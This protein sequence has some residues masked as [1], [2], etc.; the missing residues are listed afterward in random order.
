VKLTPKI[1]KII[2]GL[3]AFAAVVILPLYAV[4]VHLKV[5]YTDFLV[6]HRGGQRALV[7]GAVYNLGD[8][9]SPFRY[10]PILIPLFSLL[11]RL[12]LSTAQLLWYFIQYASF[13]L[14]LYFIYRTLKVTEHSEVKNGESRALVVTALTM[15]FI[16]RFCL[17]TF[18]IGQVSSLMFL[19]YCL[20]LYGFVTHRF[21]L[22]GSGLFIPT[23]LKIGP[24]IS[25]TLF[26]FSRTSERLRA[27]LAPVLITAALTL[28]TVASFGWKT[29]ESWIRG[30]ILIVSKDDQ[31]YDASHYGSQSLKSVLL[32]F[33]NAGVISGS[34]E[35]VIL[36]TVTVIGCV[37]LLAFWRLR[38]PTDARARGVFFSLGIFPYLWFMPETFKYSLTTL[39]LPISFLLMSQFS[40]QIRGRERSRLRTFA[41]LFM[42]FGVSAAG[43]DLLPDVIFFGLQKSSVPFI[44]SIF[45]AV[46]LFRE[47]CA[48]SVTS[49][50]VPNYALGPWKNLPPDSLCE[51]SVIAPISELSASSEVSDLSPYAVLESTC[52]K[53][54]TLY[55]DRWEWIGVLS[56]TLDER[57]KRGI[58]KTQAEISKRIP[59][60]RLKFIFSESFGRSAALRDGFLQSTGKTVYL[61]RWEQPVDADFVENASKLVGAPHHTDHVTG[62]FSIVRANRRLQE[63]RFEIPV[64]HLRVAYS[65]HRLGLLFNR[66]V[67]L[68]LPIIETTDTHSGHVL[69]E[70]S[71]ASQIFALQTSPDFLFDLEL[72]LTAKAY[73]FLETELPVRLYLFEE[74]SGGRIFAEMI[75]ILTGLPRLASRYRRGCY[76]PLETSRGIT[77]D[78]W[79]LSPAINQGILALAKNGTIRRVSLMSN[80]QYLTDGLDELK[81]VPGIQLGLHFNLTYGKPLT[82]RYQPLP[83]GKFLLRWITKKKQVLPSLRT[84][85]KAQLDKLTSL[86][87]QPAYFDGHHHIH[88]VPG[89]LDRIADL[90]KA[91]GIKTVRLPYDP[92]LKFSPKMPLL[93]F[94]L[95]TQSAIKK[96][97]FKTMI[98]FYP[99]LIHFQDHGLLRSKINQNPEAEVIVHPAIRNDLNQIEFPDSYTDGRVRE[100]LALQMLCYVQDA[101]KV[102]RVSV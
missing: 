67:R 102:F 79:G 49:A 16:L 36:L 11:G 50:E 55:G 99:K 28:I 83:P 38:K 43:K 45:L 44:A 59:K 70:R 53:L 33:V 15:F 6:Y 51:F 81:R 68:F 61:M 48:D 27:W 40:T 93:I 54:N 88:T 89:L 2:S 39:A 73:G 100:Y 87:I 35:R 65:R 34:E 42:F 23:I 26:L 96:H 94:S 20:G 46:A 64:K 72:A 75:S 98:V 19:G 66:L 18:T 3:A 52:E 80:C 56:P 97:G 58:E 86:G 9:S 90:V 47:A 13:S 76:R 32:R 14:G 78:D 24:G 7:G 21:F 74:K 17:D 85:L 22:S 60:G 62:K 82:P 101:Q 69:L 71:A 5:D 95:L 31:Y 30:W 1:S 4:K 37:A 29:L 92:D 12:E 63:S 8:G 84:E 91:A 25:Y 57:E 41:L 10:V 77:A